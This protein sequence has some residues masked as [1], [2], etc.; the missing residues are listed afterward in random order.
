MI[1]EKERGRPMGE[2]WA[3]RLKTV[4]QFILN[5]RLLLCFGIGWMITNGWSY[6]LL[7]LGTWLNI[8]WMIAVSGAYLAFLWFPFSPEKLLTVAIAIF[9][10]RRL[11]PND[12]KTLAVLIEMKMKIVA[13]VKKRKENK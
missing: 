12:Q 3:R 8:P 10:L 6:V 1:D 5:P 11:F 13:I 4:A 9:L 2:K 7:G